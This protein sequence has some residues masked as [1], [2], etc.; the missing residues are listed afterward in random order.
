[1]NK[2]LTAN[3]IAETLGVDRRSVMLRLGDVLPDGTVHGRDAWTLRTFWRASEHRR[4]PAGALNGDGSADAT[5]GGYGA[6]RAKLTAEKARL[7]ELERLERE[8]ALVPADQVAAT[9]DGLAGVI[10]TKLLALPAKCAAR[11][12]MARNAVEVQAILKAEV[13]E[14]LMEL[15]GTAVRVDDPAATIQR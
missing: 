2:L 4:K 7:A 8:C 6:E 1:M 12:G 11:V 13:H 15:P 5:S 14:L 10:R 3:G 9:W